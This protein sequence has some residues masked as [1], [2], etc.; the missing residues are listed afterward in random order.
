MTDFV[1]AVAAGG[2]A[3]LEAVRDRVAADL[4]ECKSYRDR[5]ALYRRLVDVLSKLDALRPAPARQLDGIDEI[6]ERRAR[7]GF[8][9]GST[10]ERFL[11][12]E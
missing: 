2:V 6:R 7:R 10:S 11:L 5:A 4:D 3:A 9:V 8:R 1:D 12:P